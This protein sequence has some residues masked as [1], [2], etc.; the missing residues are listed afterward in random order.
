MLPIS[1]YKEE[2]IAAVLK[3]RNVIISSRPGTGKSTLLPEYLSSYFDK[4]SQTQE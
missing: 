1:K 3:H 2:I 4:V